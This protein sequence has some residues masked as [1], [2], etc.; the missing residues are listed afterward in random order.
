M[1]NNTTT[2]ET[3]VC[4]KCQRELPLESYHKCSR[5][6]SGRQSSCKSCKAKYH[7]KRYAN[8]KE[9]INK[10]NKKWRDKNK[11]YFS[12]WKEENKEY[13]SAYK[14]SYHKKHRERN[15]EYFRNWRKENHEYLLEYDRKRYKQNKK[16][17]LR[18]SRRYQ[19]ENKDKI[20]AYNQKRRNTKRNLPATLTSEQWV[21]IKRTF[22][23]GCAYCG[24]KDPLSQEHFI[25]LNSGGEYTHDNII[26]ACKSCNSSKQD[27]SFFEWYPQQEFYSKTRERKILK[28]LNY[29]KNHE[30]QLSIL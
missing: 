15:L 25:P 17:H 7:Q 29:N 16:E 4:K 30:Q 6:K 11:E 2:L 23:Y 18:R 9:H 22:N 21:T 28:H 14:K 5:S 19:L 10:V 8:N 20:K 3:K 12:K 26:P 1:N 13:Y 27:K 24:R